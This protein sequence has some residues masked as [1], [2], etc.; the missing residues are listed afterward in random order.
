M[1]VESGGD[2]DEIGREGRE[3]H[4]EPLEHRAP[5]PL[6]RRA[7]RHRRVAHGGE[8]LGVCVGGRG[9]RAG[10]EAALGLALLVGLGAEAV[11]RAEEDLVRVRA[12]TRVWVRA[13]ADLV[14]VVLREPRLEGAR[15]QRDRARAARPLLA[16]LGGAQVA[17]AGLGAVAVVHVEVDDGHALDLPDRVAHR[18]QRVRRADGSRGEHAEA[19]RL[20]AH[21]AA[22]SRVV[23]RRAHRAE[24]VARAAEAH[25]AHRLDHG[26]RGAQ[27][28]A[29]RVLRDLGVGVDLADGGRRAVAALG[30]L[31]RELGAHGAH[32][33]HVLPLVHAEHVRQRGLGRRAPGERAEGGGT[34]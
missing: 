34:Q 2:D 24:G 6:R 16:H 3:R 11:D 12:R 18:V 32:A 1:R 23:A 29:V 4:E 25:A 30:L 21:R 22:R 15:L 7:Q 13:E 20:P 17:H 26:A 5:P 9:A 19:R 8:S 31:H 27:R 28:G 10:V 33:A 14:A